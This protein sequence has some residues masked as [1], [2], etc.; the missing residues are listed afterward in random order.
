MMDLLIKFRWGG[1]GWT[2]S[3]RRAGQQDG[4]GFKNWVIEVIIDVI[5]V[6]DVIED[7]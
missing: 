4:L 3:L 1:D 2:R 6:I 5:D 7:T